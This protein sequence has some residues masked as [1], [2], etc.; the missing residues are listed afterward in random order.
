MIL[1]MISQFIDFSAKC[2]Q[3]F[4][5]GSMAIGLVHP[6]ACLDVCLTNQRI[7]VYKNNK[8]GIVKYYKSR[9]CI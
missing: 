7:F 4:F 8:K 6:H 9:L 1:K 3:T 5:L 2:V